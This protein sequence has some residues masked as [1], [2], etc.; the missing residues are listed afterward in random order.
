MYKVR[1]DIPGVPES[2]QSN[3]P[4]TL[5][6]GDTETLSFLAFGG[7]LTPQTAKDVGPGKIIMRVKGTVSYN[8][9]F[10]DPHDFEVLSRYS[11]RLQG[12][13][14]EEHPDPEDVENS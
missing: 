11:Y 2:D 3:G 14:H 7:F 1:L 5:G 12:F 6:P 9:I 4:T 8:E 10:G 13:R